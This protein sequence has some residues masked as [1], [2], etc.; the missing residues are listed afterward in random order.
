VKLSVRTKILGGYAIVLVLMGVTQVAGMIASGNQATI[1]NRIVNHLDPARIAAA[2]IVTLVRSADDDGAWVVGS[3]SGDK[4]HSDQLAKDYYREVDELKTTVAT[5]LA[6]ADTD[7]QR[8]AIQEFTDFYWGT[9][10]LTDADRATLDAQSQSVFKGSDSYLFANEQV[11]AEA[12]SGQFLKATFDYTTVPYVPALDSA[13]VY[14]DVVAKQIDQATADVKSAAELTQTLSLG[15]G[16]LTVLIGLAIGFFLSRRMVR[17]VK[18]VQGTLTSLADR[19]STWLAEGL[20]RLRDGDLTYEITPVT[21]RIDKYSSDEVG[22]SAAK[23]DEL[24]DRIVAAIGAYNEARAGLANTVTQVKEAAVSVAR[25]SSQLNSAASQAG[26]ATQQIAQTIGQ[27]AAGAADQA[28]A[29]TQTSSAVSDLGGLIGEVRR[30]ATEVGSQVDRSGA[31]IAAL[32]AALHDTAEASNAVAVAAEGAGTAATSG[33]ESVRKTVNG[34]HRIKGAVDEAAG[35][36]TEIAA[37]SEQIGAIVE[38]IDDIAEQTNLLALN[39]AIEAA[40]AGEMGKGFAV[41]ADEVRKLAER[42]G[43]ATKE[44]AGLIGEVQGVISSAV[45]AMQVGATEVDTGATLA[46]EAGSS[47]DAIAGAVG[48]VNAAVGRIT[49]S[50][51]AMTGASTSVVGAMDSIGNLARTN[52]A[53]AGTMAASSGEVSHSVESIAAISEENSAAAEEVS[54]ATEELS[55]QVEEVVA[56]VQSLASMASQLD[57]LVAGFKLTADGSSG[58]RVV[59]LRSRKAA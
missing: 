42:S 16:I 17:D 23:T 35:K 41:V 27:V 31:D 21:P 12:R 55:A 1:T 14:I 53:A 43:R 5:A 24:R 48:E 54:A 46:D 25:T 15:L 3:M 10:P 36:V 7:V 38:T 11:F 4:A 59:E 52:D 18:A 34:M 19:C 58:G 47:L 37:K 22:A 40:R 32:T 44:I 57:A 39:A 33:T 49:R 9:K 2:R 8:A 50:V 28:S 56:S 45:K 29:A 26:A 51:A 6:L 30:S 13:Q 20:G